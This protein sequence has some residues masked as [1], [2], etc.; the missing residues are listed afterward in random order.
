MSFLYQYTPLPQ[1]ITQYISQFTKPKTIKDYRD[2]LCF[3]RSCGVNRNVIQQLFNSSTPQWD[4]Q[5]I[6][7]LDIFSLNIGYLGYSLYI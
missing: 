5:E 3:P 6:A 1:V 2:I 7:N 4:I